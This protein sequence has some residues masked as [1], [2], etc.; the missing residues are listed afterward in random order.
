MGNCWSFLVCCIDSLFCSK[1][2]RHLASATLTA[3]GEKEMLSHSLCPCLCHLFLP[4]CSKEAGISLYSLC[5]DVGSELKRWW[6]WSGWG[7]ITVLHR[8]QVLYTIP[9]CH[10]CRGALIGDN[11]KIINWVFAGQGNRIKQMIPCGSCERS[12]FWKN[13]LP[14]LQ[15]ASPILAGKIPRGESLFYRK[16]WK[17]DTVFNEELEQ[18]KTAILCLYLPLQIKILYLSAQSV[19]Q[20]HELLMG[21]A[22]I[23]L[24]I[25]EWTK[26]VLSQDHTHSGNPEQQK[27]HRYLSQQILILLELFACLCSLLGV[28]YPLLCRAAPKASTPAYCA[29]F[30]NYMH[31]WLSAEEPEIITPPHCVTLKLVVKKTYFLSEREGRLILKSSAR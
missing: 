18:L 14:E 2:P 24:S 5:L 27:G 30:K 29:I 6:G 15:P 1:N 11:L 8:N 4:T 13:T 26:A 19:H 31:I 22:G 10:K 25:K 20:I 28:L 23:G 21:R 7:N 9:P 17:E 12:I 16:V 3:Q